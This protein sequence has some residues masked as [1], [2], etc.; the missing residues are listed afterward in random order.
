MTI[1]LLFQPV[2]PLGDVA[3]YF[4]GNGFLYFPVLIH[5]ASGAVLEEVVQTGIFLCD[6]ILRLRQI[7]LDGR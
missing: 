6:V 4:G 1:T 2:Y 3:E 7:A 5:A